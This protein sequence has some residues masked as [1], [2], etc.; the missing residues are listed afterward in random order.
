[1]NSNIFNSIILSNEQVNYLMGGTAG[2]N[3]LSCLYQLIQIVTRQIETSNEVGEST[4]ALWEVNMSEVAL[5]KLWKC[6]RKTVSKM[7][8]HMNK[9]GI[10]SSVQTRRGSVH[11]LLCISAWIVDGKKFVNPHYVPINQRDCSGKS[12]TM[13]S[14]TAFPNKEDPPIKNGGTSPTQLANS[15]FSSLTSGNG[16]N[17]EEEDVPPPSVSDMDKAEIVKTNLLPDDISP[18]AMWAR[19]LALQK[20]F[21]DKLNRYHPLKRNMIRIE[22][23]PT[24]EE[25]QGWTMEDWQSLADDFI[26]E[27]DAVDLSAKTKRKSAKTTN[28]KDSQYVVALHRDSKSGIMHLHI[29]ANRIDMRGNVNDAHYIYE[30]AMAAAAKVGQQRGWKDA[31]EVSRQNKEAI[32][33]DCLSVLAKMPYFDWGLYT[34]CLTQMGYDVKLQSDN[35]GQ[36]RGYAIKRGNSIYKS[37][38]L[39]KGRCLMPSKIEGTWAK[40]HHQELEKPVSTPT[41]NTQQPKIMTVPKPMTTADNTPK[42]RHFDFYTDEFHHYP[43]DIPQNCLDVIDKNMALDADN[44]FAK[45]GDVQKTAILLFAE[46]IDAATT[47]AAQSGGGGGGATSGWGRDKDEDELSWAY[48]CAM[49]ANR[50]CRPR[51][52]QGYS[53]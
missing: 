25:T 39:G 49:M 21:E 50:L 28:L 14:T 36:V 18:M 38:E 26:R 3:R 29:D 45:I 32:T 30:R 44:V 10:L 19:M 6:D 23:S 13:T 48:R 8:D 27:F 51:K 17:G 37:S 47:I 11:T 33:N 22:V 9:L 15:S 42:I 34:K 4:T 24:S 41:K 40:L 53:R 7:L 5:S 31:Q 20:K 52:K 16:D 43:V 35:K 46:Y 1:M 12:N 2:I